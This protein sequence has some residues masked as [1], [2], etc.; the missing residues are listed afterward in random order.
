M[1]DTIWDGLKSAAAGQ[2]RFM[3]SFLIASEFALLCVRTKDVDVSLS[4]LLFLSLSK[5][6]LFAFL[7]GVCLPATWQTF[8]MKKKTIL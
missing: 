2:R 5:S 7:C 6:G 8:Y 1:R 3:L 4:P